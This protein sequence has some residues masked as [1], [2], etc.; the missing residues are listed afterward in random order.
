LAVWH[1][2]DSILNAALPALMVALGARAALAGL[3]TSVPALVRFSVQKE[4]TLGFTFL[5][6]AFA[7]FAFVSNTQG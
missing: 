1:P 3:A 5:T 2:N 7:G 6:R 4:L